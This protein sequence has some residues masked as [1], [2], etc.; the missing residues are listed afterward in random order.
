MMIVEKYYE[1]A[2]GHSNK[3]VVIAYNS[4]WGATH[5]M[6]EFI[7]KGL[8][9]SGIEY[10]IFN[11][12]TA[13][14]NDM[15]AEV[16]KAKGIILGSSTVNNG[17]LTSL[18]PLIEDLIGLKFEKKV[19]AAFG[20]YGWSG[21]STDILKDYLNK[22]RLKVIWNGLKIKYMPDEQELQDCITF[23]KNFAEKMLAEM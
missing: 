4:M 19:G 6:A 20:S 17:L 1:W 21:E 22:A 11:V 18:L 3:S 15:V 14:R 2:A 12:A 9:E 23:G 16:F 10:K 5:K 13:D 7:G 8:G